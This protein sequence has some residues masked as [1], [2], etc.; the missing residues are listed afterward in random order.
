MHRIQRFRQAQRSDRCKGRFLQG[1]FAAQSYV[2]D[3]HVA[4]V[5]VI[6]PCKVCRLIKA[7]AHF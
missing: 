4:E 7:M 2:M 3:W 6:G 1:G 5:I